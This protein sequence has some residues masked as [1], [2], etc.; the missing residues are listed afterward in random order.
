MSRV[1]LDLLHARRL[2]YL[3]KYKDSSTRNIMHNNNTIA[4]TP[5]D[6]L[7]RFASQEDLLNAVFLDAGETL[8]PDEPCASVGGGTQQQQSQQSEQEYLTSCKPADFVE[9]TKVQSAAQATATM[10]RAPSGY[11]LSSSSTSH[12]SE[13]TRAMPPSTT[14]TTTAGPKS[15]ANFCPKEA[16][17]SCTADEDGGHVSLTSCAIILLSLGLRAIRHL[18]HSY[19][20]NILSMQESATPPKTSSPFRRRS[21]S[22]AVAND[23]K[24]STQTDSSVSAADQQ[25]DF[26]DT[27]EEAYHPAKDA[28]TVIPEVAT[29]AAAAAEEDATIA[30]AEEDTTVVAGAEDDATTVAAD[31]MTQMEETSS[32]KTTNTQLQ[33][34]KTE[35]PD[36]VQLLVEE[37]ESK[38]SSEKGFL[39]GRN[40][41][42]RTH[43]M[44]TVHTPDHRGFLGLPKTSLPGGGANA[45]HVGGLR[46]VPERRVGSNLGS[47]FSHT[48]TSKPPHSRMS[49][50]KTQEFITQAGAGA[51]ATHNNQTG[52]LPPWTTTTRAATATTSSKEVPIAKQIAKEAVLARVLVP[53]PSPLPPSESWFAATTSFRKPLGSFIREKH[54]GFIR[55]SSASHQDQIPTIT[56]PS[57]NN[58]NSSSSS[59][60]SSSNN[61]NNNNNSQRICS[62]KDL[63]QRRQSFRPTIHA[64]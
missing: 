55:K 61:N 26:Y 7:P 4:T 25:F 17:D 53:P 54:A 36:Q 42:S 52:L 56:Q 51:G 58:N 63:L 22:K 37:Q 9:H 16:D 34:Q 60:S 57:N 14:T 8:L 2:V 23:N 45:Q 59:S 10:E 38:E 47:N 39:Q 31:S 20:N 28:T 50:S 49:S 6:D 35:D 33:Q 32:C 43:S 64:I 24:A 46:Q 3:G 44:L 48:T 27:E 40:S 41:Y 62:S 11:P 5:T 30:A 1:Q 29:V 12:S 21:E 19:Q 18:I 13:E 15:S